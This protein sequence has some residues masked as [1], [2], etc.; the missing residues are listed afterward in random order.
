MLFEEYEKGTGVSSQEEYQL[1]EKFYTAMPEG[2]SKQK[3]FE[4][5]NAMDEQDFIYM[6]ELVVDCNDR[7]AET[8][9]SY[10]K[11]VEKAVFLTDMV[12]K[13]KEHNVDCIDM[14]AN[15]KAEDAKQQ[16]LDDVKDMWDDIEHGY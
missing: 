10:Q 4:L 11:D 14:Y 5:R 16:I 2:F 1:A 15:F 7:L 9:R 8:R 12:Y 3:L 6:C 13:L